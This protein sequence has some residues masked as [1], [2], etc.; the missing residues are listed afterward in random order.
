LTRTSSQEFSYLVIREAEARRSIPRD[1]WVKLVFDLGQTGIPINATDLYLQVIYK[2][3]LG[4]EKEGVAVGLKDISEPT[5]IDLFN[6][7]DR[8][9]MGGTWYRAGSPDAIA[10]VDTNEDGIADLWDVYPHHLRDHYLRFSPIDQPKWVSFKEFDLYVPLMEAGE[11]RRAAFLLTD[12]RFNLSNTAAPV[13]AHPD[14]GWEH[15]PYLWCTEEQ[16]ISPCLF[17]QKGIKNQ[18]NREEIPVC[19]QLMGIPPCRD[20]DDPNCCERVVLQ[21]CSVRHYPIPNEYRGVK[22]WGGIRVHNQEYPAGAS[23]PE[24]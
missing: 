10:L 18:T 6:D 7:M 20:Y 24:D 14:D 21:P 2:G 11:F 17:D 4:L 1:E 5:P 16:Q 8:I 13:R 12:D 3:Q 19:C 15:P 22:M 23:C 9:C